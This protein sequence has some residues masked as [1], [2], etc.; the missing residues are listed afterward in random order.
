MIDN[1]IHHGANKVLIN[2][3]SILWWTDENFAFIY[4]QIKTYYPLFCQKQNRK[5]SFA[6]VLIPGYKCCLGENE[7]VY[8]QF[9]N[10]SLAY[11]HKLSLKSS[12][13]HNT[14]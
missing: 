7:Y 9:L 6:E 13:W 3:S 14:L 11:S 8:A 5:Q 10:M 1:Q 4:H 12:V 2:I